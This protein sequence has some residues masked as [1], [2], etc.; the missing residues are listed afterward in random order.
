[1]TPDIIRLLHVEDDLDILEIASMSIEMAGGFELLQ[2]E[3]ATDALR[4]AP[5]FKPDAMLFD[6]MLPK[7]SG[8]QLMAAIRE[9]PGFATTPIIFMTAR[10][11]P[12]ERRELIEKGALDVIVKPFDP[13]S[14][15]DQIKAILAAA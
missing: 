15:G 13:I 2:C 6:M 5:E 14:L 12:H 9:V 7:M 3:N 8:V 4:M 11:Q 1:M 10:A